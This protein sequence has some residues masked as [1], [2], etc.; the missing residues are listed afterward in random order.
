MSQDQTPI[1]PGSYVL[2]PLDQ[3]GWAEIIDGKYKGRKVYVPPNSRPFVPAVVTFDD[4]I[5]I[6]R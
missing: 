6:C 4:E 3:W 2:G 5:T 1:P